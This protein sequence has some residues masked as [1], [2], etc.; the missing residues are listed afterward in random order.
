MIEDS[1]LSLKKAY[2]KGEKLPKKEVQNL[3]EQSG[4]MNK[5]LT[6]PERSPNTFA[7]LRGYMWR[8]LELSE[9]R[10]T[11]TLAKVQ[12]WIELLV[13]KSYIEERFALEG[14]MDNLLLIVI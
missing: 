13:S 10:F 2:E 9:I 11:N 6:T 5:L 4:L 8:L 12:N 7:G 1:A 3:V 14:K